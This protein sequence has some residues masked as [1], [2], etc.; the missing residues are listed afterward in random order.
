[1]PAPGRRVADLSRAVPTDRGEE[2]FPMHEAMS[3]ARIR[4]VPV[5]R[6][7]ALRPARVVV[8]EAAARR[9]RLFRG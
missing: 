8:A 3:R 1:M 5:V 7:R 6:Y 4:T 2:M 9:A